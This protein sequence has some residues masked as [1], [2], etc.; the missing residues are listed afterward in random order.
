MDLKNKKITWEVKEQ[1]DVLVKQNNTDTGGSI[2]VATNFNYLEERV[3]KLEKLLKNIEQFLNKFFD[4][5]IN[6]E[7]P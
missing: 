7:K 5:E 1:W 6:K 2:T 4:T 3:E